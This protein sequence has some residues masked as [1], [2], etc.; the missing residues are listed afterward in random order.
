MIYVERDRIRL[1]GISPLL[2]FDFTVFRKK[3]KKERFVSRNSRLKK[4]EKKE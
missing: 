3:K 4:K 1:G 2:T